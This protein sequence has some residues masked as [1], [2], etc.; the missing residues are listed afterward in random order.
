M[1][2]LDLSTQSSIQLAMLQAEQES[3]IKNITKILALVDEMCQAQAGMS[4]DQLIDSYDYC[5]EKLNVIK[6]EKQ[7]REIT[8]YI[9]SL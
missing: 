6:S 8:N 2:A 1:K 4:L 9:E 5:I 7:S 3:N